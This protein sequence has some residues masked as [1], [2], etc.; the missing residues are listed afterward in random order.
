MLPPHCGHSSFKARNVQLNS[1]IAIPMTVPHWLNI[2][3]VFTSGSSEAPVHDFA[4]A[5]EVA[6]LLSAGCSS[7]SWHDF[8]QQKNRL[9]VVVHVLS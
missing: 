7:A 1:L 8:A 6:R 3:S 9:K 2:G 4:G 5:I